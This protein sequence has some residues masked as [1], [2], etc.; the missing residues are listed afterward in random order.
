MDTFMDQ[1]SQKLNAQQIIRANGEAESEAM[2][3][4]RAQVREYQDCLDRMK[5]VADELGGLQ[6]TIAALPDLSAGINDSA[7]EGL[8]EEMAS[9]NRVNEDHLQKLQS[10]LLANQ[11]VFIEHLDQI[12]N[13]L[14]NTGN[15]DE[16]NARIDRLEALIGTQ[17]TDFR[18]DVSDEMEVRF[19]D[20]KQGFGNDMESKLGGLKTELSSN[21][22][23]E[24]LSARLDRLEAL[25][26]SQLGDL[27]Q[28]VNTDFA[29]GIGSLKQD[30][31]ADLTAGLDLLGQDVSAKLDS[32]KSGNEEN[33]EKLRSELLAQIAESSSDSDIIE[34]V[35][36]LR[37]EVS[38]MKLQMDSM[39]T[40][41][42]QYL[43]TMQSNLRKGQ[44]EMLQ[45]TGSISQ[46]LAGADV[47]KECVR[48]YRNVQAS[49]QDENG[50]LL[51]NIR[52]E[53]SVQLES[54]KTDSSRH[55][56]VIKDETAKLL[57]SLRND[58]SK[59]L[60]GLREENSKF[61]V[62][63]KTETYKID[64]QVKGVRKL[65]LIALIASILSIIA[66]FIAKFL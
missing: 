17:L 44:E 33:I 23:N 37:D 51:D 63:V 3:V 6:Q 4:M 57:G 53:N 36:V 55:I 46:A 50:K 8:K 20:L 24:E 56:T 5:T 49:I 45:S 60:E 38:A 2:G 15:N 34:R 28:G 47:H 1:L 54:I 9:M 26:G 61:L 35:E 65:A 29:S 48:V 30:V 59:Q 66:P 41:N 43:Q 18:N 7:L 52:Q 42:D 14:A 64:E 58:S 32:V 16:V 39:R 22:G 11:D 21:D 19:Q 62:S 40:N 27:K 10:D 25:I 13:D 31:S 12:R